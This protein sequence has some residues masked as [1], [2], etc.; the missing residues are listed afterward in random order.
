MYSKEQEDDF[1]G[2]SVPFCPFIN[3]KIVSLGFCV[4]EQAKPQCDWSSL[5]GQDK[6]YRW[7]FLGNTLFMKGVESE[8]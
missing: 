6:C 4:V 3:T 1:V 5:Y 8:S 7:H 2:S